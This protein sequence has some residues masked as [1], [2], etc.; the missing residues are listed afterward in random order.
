MVTEMSNKLKKVAVLMGG[1]ASERPV[2]LSTGRM[3]LEALDKSRY[4]ATPIDTEN[5]TETFATLNALRP[6]VVFI[7]LHGKGGEDGSIQGMLE[8]LGLPYTGSGVLAS[9]LAMDKAMSKRLFRSAGLP[10]IEDVQVAEEQSLSGLTETVRNHLGGCPVFVKPNAEGSTFGCTLVTEES[11][12]AAAVET[13]L[14]Y[15]SLALIEKYIGGMEI[16]AGIL[17]NAGEELMT[18]PLIEIVPKSKFYDY[19]SKYADGGSDHRLLGNVTDGF[20]G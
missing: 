18:L 3:I 19:E 11:Q 1:K 6:D 10:V 5:I 17:G 7:A 14:Q 16:T 20:S 8:L 12:L 13:A 15:D 4:A 2:S 9:A